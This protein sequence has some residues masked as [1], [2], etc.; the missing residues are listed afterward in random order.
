MQRLA[1]SAAGVALT[2]AFGLIN[3]SSAQATPEQ[4]A[5]ITNPSLQ[6]AAEAFAEA[7]SRLTPSIVRADDGTLELETT[8]A[9]SGI[10]PETFDQVVA[11]LDELN[12][13]VLRGE[14]LTNEQLQVFP[15]SPSIFHNGVIYYWWGMEVHFTATTTSKITNAMNA[16]AGFSAIVAIVLPVVG[17]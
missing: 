17:T 15:A 1:V 10:N 4:P 7:T 14:L 12:Q 2:L 3:P 13:A 16:G 9:D 8:A 5:V 11:S 6:A